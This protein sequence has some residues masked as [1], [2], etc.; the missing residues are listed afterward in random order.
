MREGRTL[1]IKVDNLPLQKEVIPKKLH[2]L[3]V[4]FVGGYPNKL[5]IFKTSVS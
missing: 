5:S 3:N 4:I 2:L 1:S